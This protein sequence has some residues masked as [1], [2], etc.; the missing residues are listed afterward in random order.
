MA[1][2][3]RLAARRPQD[4][5]ARA[6]LG[7]AYL[8]AGRFD[9]AVAAFTEA[10]DLGDER[11]GTALGLALGDIALGRREH[12]LQVLDARR[13]SLAP[14]DR[15]LALALAGE[16]ARGV[17]VLGEAMRAGPGSARLR[18]NLALA[19]ALD[20][21]WREAWLMAAQDLPPDRARDRVARWALMARPQAERERVAHLLGAPLRS[22]PGYPAALALA[23]RQPAGL[24]AAPLP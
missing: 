20:G 3:E 19:Y 1:G 21:R 14:A 16:A 15:G 7:R 23:P 5:A 4:A 24:A 10:L 6:A 13:D 22:D 8:A 18:Q 2:A 9:S 12:A 17:A 11:P